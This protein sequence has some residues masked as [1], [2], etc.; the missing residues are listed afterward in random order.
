MIIAKNDFIK[1]GKYM[2]IS[3]FTI[4]HKLCGVNISALW[5]I[6]KWITYYYYIKVKKIDFTDNDKNI[7]F[8]HFKKFID[9]ISLENLKSDA[10]TFFY[11]PDIKDNNIDLFRVKKFISDDENINDYLKYLITLM[12]RNVNEEEKSNILKGIKNSE[13]IDYDYSAT[14]RNDISFFKT[15]GLIDTKTENLT[16]YG[17]IVLN[18][19]FEVVRTVYE[20]LKIFIYADSYELPNIKLK[21]KSI[22]NDIKK[23]DLDK[24]YNEY[25]EII[26]DSY[27]N[28]EDFSGFKTFIY[29]VF[30]E[31]LHMKDKKVIPQDT[32]KYIVSRVAP[33]DFDKVKDILE[34]DKDMDNLISKLDKLYGDNGPDQKDFDKFIYGNEE[35]MKKYSGIR[36]TDKKIFDLIAPCILN[37]YKIIEKKY[38][39]RYHLISLYRENKS[40]NEVINILRKGIKLDKVENNLLNNYQK[41]L[42]ENLANISEYEKEK[43]GHLKKF[44][45]LSNKY[46]HIDKE[47]RN[48]NNDL[49]IKVY[50][51][52]KLIDL[53]KIVSN[54][55]NKSICNALYNKIRK[56]P[57]F[58][59]LR[60]Y[61]K[62]DY[63]DENYELNFED[64]TN[65]ISLYLFI[66][67]LYKDSFDGTKELEKLRIK[68]N[69]YISEVLS[70][71]IDKL[72][73]LVVKQIHKII[74]GSDVN[75]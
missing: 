55:N 14:A 36:I 21:T 15:L 24:S 43:F 27:R 63:T 1:P 20:Y 12:G 60:K 29:K 40:I 47:I 23:G 31:Y 7:I 8:N 54:L 75:E 19:N 69:N 73:E 67:Y 41:I 33:Y 68:P 61:L 13:N 46:Y 17:E 45:N 64:K 56:K 32:Y 48:I 52:T 59:P 57:E 9:S 11:T 38:S 65:L 16:K 70:L 44:E 37:I 6:K 53:Y 18:G 34:K 28:I 22:S 25:F 42:N 3:N 26:K 74:E 66:Y 30:I 51:Y 49:F 71:E 5:Y 58:K 62:Y 35:F 50:S 39:E 10:E 4:P 72:E 2:R